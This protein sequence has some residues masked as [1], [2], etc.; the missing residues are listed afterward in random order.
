MGR[1]P[2]DD[3]ITE[4]RAVRRPKGNRRE[5]ENPNPEARQRL[6]D[7]AED[8]VEEY[9][10][11][12]IR[13]NDVA[14]MAGLSVGTFYLYF[15]GKADLLVQLVQERTDRLKERMAA[16]QDGTG[17]AAEQLDRGLRVYLDFVEESPRAFLHFLAAGALETTHG[18]LANWAVDQHA[19]DLQP[20]IA[21]A[22]DAGEMRGHDPELLAQGLTGLVQHLAGFWLEHREHY[23]RRDIVEFIREFTTFG[24]S[25]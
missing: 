5:L 11:A 13:V 19:A 6:L 18:R 3:T 16:E 20:L 14:K 23:D 4:M 24:I 21:Q 7:A 8:L 22:I 1:R 17:T 25:P 10:E 12:D 9:G 15:D 2:G